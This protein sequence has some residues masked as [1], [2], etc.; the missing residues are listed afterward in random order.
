MN[1]NLIPLAVHLARAYEIAETGNHRI[2]LIANYE[3]NPAIDKRDTQSFID[4]YKIVEDRIDPE[5]IVELTAIDSDTIIRSF[6][7]SSCEN[8]EDINLRIFET[9]NNGIEVKNEI[10]NAS[11]TL[12]KTAIDRLGLAFTDVKHIL[13]VAKTIAKMSN[14]EKIRV[15]HLAEAIQ[16]KSVKLEKF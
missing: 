9:Q 3:E 2:A 16:Y 11:K 1:Y 14:S 12:L 6:M 8:L 13:S 4:F 15:E 5:I 7:N 10:C